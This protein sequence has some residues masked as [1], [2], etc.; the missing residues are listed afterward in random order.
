MPRQK[1]FSLEEAVRLVQESDENVRQIIA[2]PPDV[3]ELTDEED[4]DCNDPKDIP[5]T[6]EVEFE[7]KVESEN[8]PITL[9]CGASAS[10]R[11]K[12]DYASN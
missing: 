12:T 6:I 4:E 8:E 5:G 3:N 9:N 10:K 11:K 1:V 7:N 2:L